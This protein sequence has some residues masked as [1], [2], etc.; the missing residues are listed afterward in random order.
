MKNYLLRKLGSAKP[1]QHIDEDCFKK[2]DVTYI[3]TS[4]QGKMLYL[5]GQGLSTRNGSQIFF[6]K[7]TFKVGNVKLNS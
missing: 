3:D 6:K 1:T 5:T 2:Y 7:I 4:L